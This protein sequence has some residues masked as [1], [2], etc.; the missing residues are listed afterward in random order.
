MVVGVLAA[1]LTL[2][3]VLV[4]VS[5]ANAA[6]VR[7]AAVA[8]LAALAGGDV[9]VV[10][11]WEDVGDKP[12]ERSR[13]VASANGA[14]VV[15]CSVVGQDLLVEVRVGAQVLGVPYEVRARA[16]AGPEE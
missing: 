9:A 7:A 12:C 3:T 8:D 2:A 15:G 11:L 6:Q 14:L 5:Q 13:Q 4:G 1:A 16:R 10:A